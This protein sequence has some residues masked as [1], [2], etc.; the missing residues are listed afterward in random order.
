MDFEYEFA[1]E[2]AEAGDLEELKRMHLA[3]FPLQGTVSHLF[4]NDNIWYSTTLAAKNGHLDCLRYA[5]E[6]GCEMSHLITVEA[7]ANGHLDCLQYAHSQGCEMSHLITA[8]AAENGHLDCLQYAHENGC[9]LGVWSAPCAAENGHIEC[10][11]YCFQKWW[12]NQHFWKIEYDL[13]NIID[14]ID[15]EDPVWSSLFTLDLTNNP[16]LKNKIVEKLKMLSI[17]ILENKIPKD[18]L[19]YCLNPFF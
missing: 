17:E 4:R 15:L 16:L 3:G 7:A 5:H 12:D 10:F 9:I 2:A 18:V 14:K 6:N 1:W 13:S 19:I 8:E 11:K